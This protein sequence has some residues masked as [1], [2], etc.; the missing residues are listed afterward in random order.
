MLTPL[1]GTERIAVSAA[2][3]VG[4]QIFPHLAIHHHLPSRARQKALIPA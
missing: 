2:D 3:L 1:A 4:K